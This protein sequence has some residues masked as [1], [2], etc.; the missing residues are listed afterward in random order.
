LK[1]AEYLIKSKMSNIYQDIQYI[2]S[3]LVIIMS[4]NKNFMSNIVC[5]QKKWY[6]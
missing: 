2:G 3:V 1:I 6:Y 4:T 5:I